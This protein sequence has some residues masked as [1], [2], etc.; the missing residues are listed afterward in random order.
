VWDSRAPVG[1]SAGMM[2]KEGDEAVDRTPEILERPLE[3]R[4]A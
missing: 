1:Y 4:A 3:G 2:A